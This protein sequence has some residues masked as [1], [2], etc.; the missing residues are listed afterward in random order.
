MGSAFF[1]ILFILGSISFTRPIWDDALLILGSYVFADRVIAVFFKV[2]NK[3]AFLLG[4]KPLRPSW[5]YVGFIILILTGAILIQKILAGVVSLNQW[6][7][8]IPSSF[9]WSAFVC[10]WLSSG[11]LESYGEKVT[12]RRGSQSQSLPP[13]D[14]AP[15]GAGTTLKQ[16]PNRAGTID[17]NTVRQNSTPFRAHKLLAWLTIPSRDKHGHRTRQQWKWCSLRRPKGGL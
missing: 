8:P 15:E 17:W 14:L 4:L 10:G 6:L 3:K 16:P 5:A 2:K 9:V 12:L 11:L 1:I 13:Q 7:G